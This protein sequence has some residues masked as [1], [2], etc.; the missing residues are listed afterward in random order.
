[1]TYSFV[2]GCD[3]SWLLW[4]FVF[5][6][7]VKLLVVLA[8]LM[9]VESVAVVVA[10]VVIGLQLQWWLWLK[11]FLQLKWL[12]WCLCLWWEILIYLRFGNHRD[13]ALN[14]SQFA[15]QNAFRCRVQEVMGILFE[16][17]EDSLDDQLWWVV[18]TSTGDAVWASTGEWELVTK[19]VYQSM[20]VFWEDWCVFVL[21]SIA[22]AFGEAWSESVDGCVERVLMFEWWSVGRTS[23]WLS[24]SCES[25]GVEWKWVCVDCCGAWVKSLVDF[26]WID[27]SVKLTSSY[28][29]LSDNT[30]GAI[31]C[32][33]VRCG[34]NCGDC[35]DMKW[36][37]IYELADCRIKPLWDIGC[38][39]AILLV[40]HTGNICMDSVV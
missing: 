34:W 18:W 2:D 22:V 10:V 32:R 40:L 4:R 3:W 36:Q 26:Q 16:L 21:K 8:V 31:G 28:G 25:S 6:F 1:M 9:V 39:N 33:E 30:A 12:L 11:W 15:D 35:R 5:G 38:A 14:L 29:V 20:F 7:V 17:N 23:K 19:N 24:A 27:N 13:F 37:K